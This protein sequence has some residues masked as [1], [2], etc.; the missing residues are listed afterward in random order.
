MDYPDYAADTS[1]HFSSTIASPSTTTATAENNTFS[2][3]LRPMN[4]FSSSPSTSLQS[5]PSNDVTFPTQQQQQQRSS[6]SSLDAERHFHLLTA[7]SS[8]IDTTP[9]HHHQEPASS[10]TEYS[11][12]VHLTPHPTTAMMQDYWHGQTPLLLDNPL[13]VHELDNVEVNHSERGIAGFVSK[14]YQ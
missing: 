10:T 8:S 3:R 6:T 13:H 9:F 2:Q 4:T 7:S 14:L 12:H 11:R 1:P 5:P